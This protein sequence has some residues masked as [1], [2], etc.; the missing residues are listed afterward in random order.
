[1]FGPA[2]VGQPP[3]TTSYSNNQTTVTDEVSNQRT[4]QSDALGR[5]TYVWEAPNVTGYNYETDYT[6]DALNNLLSVT[7]K[8]GSSSSSNWRPR[9]FIYD[10]LSRLT[11]AINPES[12]IILYSYDPNGNLTSKV[13]PKPNAGSTGTV[14]TNYSYDALNRLT[15]K[16][17]VGLTMTA[18]M[19]GY[20]GTTLVGCGQ[21]P[22]VITFTNPIGRRTAM[23]SGM[24]GSSW[25]YDPM[26]RPSLESRIDLNPGNGP[27]K[28][29]GYTYYLDGS[30]NTLTYPSGKILTY[31][32][33]GAGRATQA[34]DPNNNYVMSAKY[35]PH[36]ALTSMTNGY[37]SSF[38]GITTLNSYNDRLQP[39]TLS[40][41]VGTSTVFSLC[42]DF[43]LGVAIVSAQ[44]NFSR[45][46]TG[47]NG[48]VFQIVNNADST[49][50]SAYIYDPLNRIA[51]AYT[52]NL[53]S[54]N[55]WGET[56]SATATASGVLPSTPGID[57][58]GNLTNRS[59]VSG[60]AGNC[61]TEPLGVT[62]TTLNQLSSLQYDPAGN[63]TND[64]FSNQPTYDAE[65]EIVSDAGV[66]YS[67]DADGKRMEKSSG[68]KYWFGPGGQA[69]T[70]T[71]FSG[72]INEEYIYFNGERIARVDRPSGTQHYYF[73]NHLG[74]AS[75]ITNATGGNPDQTDFY[76]FGGIAYS[77]GSDPNHY[78]F[79]GKERDAESG[80]DNFD[81]RYFGS[82]LGRF[83]SADDGSDQ[84]ADNPQSWN[85]YSYVRNNPLKYTDPDGH[86][87]I[88]I[89]NDSGEM[90]GFN[91]GDC[92]NS[93]EEKANSGVYVNGT[94]NSI[95]LNG[96]D[97][98][99]GYSGTG[100]QFGVFT[101]GVIQPPGAAPPPQVNDPG[102]IPGMLGPGDLIL[103]SGVK[104]PSVVTDLFGKLFGSILG[105]GAED[106]AETAS[107]IVPDV[108]N[109]SNK[110]VR[111]MVTRGW[112]KQEILDTVNAGKT[113]PVVNKATGGAA[114][115][116]VSASGK[117]VVVDNATKQV[118]QVS[119]PGF[120]PN[121][122]AP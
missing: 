63:V 87:C 76:P 116:Y 52:V 121:H 43:H 84:D 83:M 91:R 58:W 73:S 10:S 95:E 38:A 2:K 18:L 105:K 15:A 90:T 40:A 44:C 89:D 37:T 69:L 48:N 64:G 92:D 103:F 97:Q 41:S 106:A 50:S 12:G 113:F 46:T 1:M 14:T 108:D 60:M 49:R 112:T 26:G 71:D 85:L 16:T 24:S 67:Y 120:L 59:G 36:G 25:S 102:M 104:L 47:D 4:S 96:Q 98:V 66:T 21:T 122:M 19:Y 56:Y 119:G 62:A 68:T 31:T 117:F 53:N 32:V 109:L 8:G 61:Y 33:L 77:S 55:C 6:Y 22:P 81:F 93:T 88:Y 30:L 82:S 13:A 115:E 111:Q 75:V 118:I 86:D 65:N 79:T 20:D 110:I 34:I 101:M 107:K 42:Y 3:V 100:D 72:N 27:K 80:L 28:N 114:T 78:K 45:Y 54:A 23:C 5:L 11:S 7:Q 70:E 29:V 51:Q 74:S 39:I 57:A 94:V 35:A 9:S 99:T 17:Y